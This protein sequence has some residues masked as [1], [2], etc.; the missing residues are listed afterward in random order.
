MAKSHSCILRKTFI[1]FCKVA[2]KSFSRQ[3]FK[4]NFFECYMALS[5]DKIATVRM[6]FSHSLVGLKPYLDYDTAITQELMEILSVFRN[7]PD[8]DV[9][10]AAE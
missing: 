4:T 5:K 8:R 2:V 10:E 1:F 3:F 6:E 9:I 7:D